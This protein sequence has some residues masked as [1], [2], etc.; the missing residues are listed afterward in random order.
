MLP[1]MPASR[2]R[3]PQARSGER[4]PQA[5]SGERAPQAR[6]GERVPGQG[7]PDARTEPR[8]ASRAVRLVDQN[9]RPLGPRATATR[10]RLLDATEALLDERR[11]REV[12]V[13]EI[14]R[15][16]GTSPATFYQYFKDVE[17]ATLELARE[18][19]AQ[20]HDALEPLRRDWRG[21]GGL[22]AARALVEGFVRRW[23]QHHAVLLFT[24][25]AAEQGD[26]RFRKVRI[27]S[28]H[29]LIDALA[30]KVA[31]TREG[32]GEPVHPVAAAAALAAIL[33]RLAAYHEE[34]EV[35]GVARGDLVETV[36]RILHQTVTGKGAA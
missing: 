14:A 18:A 25:V 16:A 36:A 21:A 5:R 23:D 8:P 26:R 20:V 17:E 13:V 7:A 2:E 1:A 11:V 12:S 6:S 31:A 34:L 19:G 32:A 35:L 3:A 27:Q 22:D 10:R 9:G 28:M 4:A 30:A 33:E 24:N 29:P 15:R